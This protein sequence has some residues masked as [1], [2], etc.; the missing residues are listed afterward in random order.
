MLFELAWVI[1]VVLLFGDLFV[2]LATVWEKAVE[3]LLKQ[4]SQSTTRRELAIWVGIYVAVSILIFIVE[5]YLIA[6]VWEAVF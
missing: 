1:L 6:T 5:V 2:V 3:K 4:I